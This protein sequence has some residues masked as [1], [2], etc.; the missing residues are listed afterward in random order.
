MAE[1]RIELDP[2]LLRQAARKTG[3]VRDRINSVMSTLQTSLAGRG[4]PWGN[5][6]IGDNF[7]NGPNGNDGY[8]ASRENLTTNS[9]NTAST[10]GNL[11]TNQTDTADYLA[12]QDRRNG[13]G[14]R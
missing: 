4:A 5:D 3:H 9:A 10:L 6:K 11:S 1:E 7:Y 8:R 14:F 12:R 2:D 13:D